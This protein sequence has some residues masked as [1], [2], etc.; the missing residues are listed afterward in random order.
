VAKPLKTHR[1][2]VSGTSSG[3]G[4]LIA[5]S[6]AEAGHVV[7]A[8]LRDPQGRDRAV[9]D[10]F[11]ALQPESGGSVTPITLDVTDDAVVAACASTLEA[12]GGVDSVVHN[13]GV[14]AAGLSETFSAEA[15]AKIFDVNVFGPHRLLRALLPQMRGRGGRSVYVSSTL[16]REVTPF[17]GLYS[18]SKA[19]LEALAEGWRYE[20]NALGIGTVVLQPG[21][22]PTTSILANL[23]PPDDPQRALAYG[24][25]AH[26]PGALFESIGALVQAGLAPDP[27]RVADA[28]VRAMEEKTPVRVVVDPSGFDGASRINTVSAQVQQELL[29]RMGLGHLAGTAVDPLERLAERTPTT[30]VSSRLSSE[31]TAQLL[32]ALIEETPLAI[33]AKDRDHRFVLSNRQHATLIARPA[34][35]ILDHTDRDLFGPEAE[36]VEASTEQV[37]GS[38]EH[39]SQEFN[40][41]LSD[42]EHTFLETIFPLVDEEGRRVGVGGIAADITARRRLEDALEERARQLETALNELRETQALLVRQ[43]K[44]A[45]LGG[46]VAGVAHEVSSP[47]G[48]ALTAATALAESLQGLEAATSDRSLTR[49]SMN[50]LLEHMQRASSL[51][52]RNLE[53]AANL[54]QSFKQVA[55]D[56][57]QRQ[58]RS[59]PLQPWLEDVVLSLSPTTRQAGVRLLTSVDPGLVPTFAASELQQIVTNLVVN[60]AVH[61]FADE[62]GVGEAPSVARPIEERRVL[63][64]VGVDAHGLRLTVEDNGRGILPEVLPRVFDP[65]YTTRRGTGGTGLG[66]H[67]TFTLVTET[68]GGRIDVTS[69]VGHGARFEV[70]LPWREG[71]LELSELPG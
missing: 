3:F 50:K 24:D 20:L 8:G 42:G 34:V 39:S 64:D 15:A 26:A 16:G 41:T 10:A 53:R 36:A 40:L 28:V 69:E 19:A 56:R 68:F 2:L 61:A 37:F 21:T 30:V 13:A 49:A 54:L 6:L 65:F 27:Q 23:V 51:T 4:R 9:A 43:Q 67:I 32:R 70:L 7:F 12:A 17:L 18:A 45:A 47:L 55:V 63:L 57:T 60:A 52:V 58:L 14:A 62:A 33:Y 22:F 48:V 5:G 31:A 38:G 59:T 44:M 71:S 46:L 1:V 66:L 29:D 11:R 35:E 25:F